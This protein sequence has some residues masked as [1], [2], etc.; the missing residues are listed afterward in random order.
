MLILCFLLLLR[1]S[2]TR[3]QRPH[4]WKVEHVLLFLFKKKV[5]LKCSNLLHYVPISFTI[6]LITLHV[7]AAISLLKSTLYQ[8][9]MYSKAWIL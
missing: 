3:K 6:T 9:L 1:I 5:F 7:V 8:S 4:G 2:Q